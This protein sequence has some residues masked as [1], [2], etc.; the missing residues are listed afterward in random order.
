MRRIAFFMISLLIITILLAGCGEKAV[1]PVEKTGLTVYT[2]FYP[3]YDITRKIGGAHVNVI[4]LVPSGIE[5]HDWEPGPQT[6]STLLA[7]DLLIVNGLGMEPWLAKLAD[8]LQGEV[9]VVDTSVGIPPLYGYTDPDDEDEHEDAT[10]IPDPHIWLDPLYALQ[11]A[12]TITIALSES[13]PLHA[14][15]YTSNLAQ[16]RS[17]VEELDNFFK[18]TLQTVK[19]REFVV[20]HLSF[21]YVA[22]RYGLTQMAI[23]GLTSHA[24]PSPAQMKDLVEFARL[25][26][27]RYIFQE[28]LAT[29][30]LAEALATEVGAKLLTLSPLEGLTPEEEAAGE[31]YFSVMRK[32]LEQLAK[33]LRE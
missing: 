9:R 7:A 29:S 23:S 20:T 8:T 22:K 3:L 14:D 28:P 15:S 27:I 26:Q 11:Q 5:P 2:S 4:N 33:A 1:E 31:D 12:E 19:R 10:A 18:E 17:Q 25:H 32:N 13:D 30:R 6:L 24:E 16:F 21:G